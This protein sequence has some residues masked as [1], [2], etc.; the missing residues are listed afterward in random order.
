M[1]NNSE[2]PEIE[3]IKEEEVKK[4]KPD[5][6]YE[7]KVKKRRRTRIP[8]LNG[9][10]VFRVLTKIIGEDP[11]K[12]SSGSHFQYPRKVGNGTYSVPL[13]QIRQC[14]KRFIIEM[15]KKFRN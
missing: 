13:S 4:P 7:S 9:T 14:W 11:E 1:Y 15:L 5:A 2:M 12:P 8:E 6:E 3:E 10:E